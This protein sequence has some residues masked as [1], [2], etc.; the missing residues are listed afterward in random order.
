V[1]S[2]GEEWPGSFEW[3]SETLKEEVKPEW[4]KGARTLDRDREFW[5]S[6]EE[7]EV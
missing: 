3:D 5:A 1:E 6:N 2:G 7:W 4:K